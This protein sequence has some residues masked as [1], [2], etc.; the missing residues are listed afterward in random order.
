MTAKPILHQQ[1]DCLTYYVF[2]NREDMGRCAAHDVANQIIALQDDQDEIRMIF[3]SAPSQNE[4]LHHLKEDRRIRWEKIVAFHMDEYIGLSEDAPQL[5]QTFLE[6]QLFKDLPFKS[7]H[8][9]N[10]S[11]SSE[12]ESER[13]SSLLQEKQIDIVCLGIGENGH[14]A[15]ND[16]P[17][18]DFSDPKTVK[19]VQLDEISRQQQ[20]ND[21]CFTSLEEVPTHA[22]TLTIPALLSAKYLYCVVPGNTKKKAIHQTLNDPISINCP[23][24]IL[25]EHAGAFLYMDSDAYVADIDEE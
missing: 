25:R 24:T 5:F 9:I 7:V 6:E 4:L 23:A 2:Q 20:V 3:A 10:S 13:Y 1:K 12:K 17:V 21:G 16:P 8:L 22:L 18:A 19:K 14:I 15:F 11:N